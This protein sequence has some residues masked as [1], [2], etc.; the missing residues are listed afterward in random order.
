MQH[1]STQSSLDSNG[2]AKSKADI[3]MTTK[4]KHKLATMLKAKSKSSSQTKQD[5]SDCKTLF[6]G[7][8]T[9]YPFPLTLI[10][11]L[12]FNLL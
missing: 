7:T 11:R 3:A 4:A 12:L 8:L 10:L 6:S 1:S 9:E 5:L 2:S